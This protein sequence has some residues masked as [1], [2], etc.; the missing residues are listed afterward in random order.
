MAA[1]REGTQVIL[2]LRDL[3]GYR[4]VEPIMVLA[5][6]AQP[7]PASIPPAIAIREL[8]DLK[9]LVQLPHR[10]VGGIDIVGVHQVQEGSGFEFVSRPTQHG[11]PRWGQPAKAGIRIS[12]TEQRGIDVDEAAKVFERELIHT[13]RH[14]IGRT[15]RPWPGIFHRALIS[16]GSLPP[17]PPPHPSSGPSMFSAVLGLFSQDLAVDV[18]TSTTRVFL[19]G[20]GII[21]TEPTVVSV[22]TRHT[23]ERRVLAIGDD[24]LPM[25]G[26]TPADIHAVRPVDEGRL[27]DYE[28]AEAFLLHL[29]RRIH[30]RNTLIRARTV[31]PVPHD[32]GDME[33]R[34]IRDA[35]EAA[36]AREVHLVPRPLA[37]ALGAD[38]PIDEPTGVMVVDLGGGRTDVAVLSMSGIVDAEVVPGGGRGMDRD[39]ALHLERHEALHIGM[40]SAEQ[41]KLELA[42][43][44]APDRSQTAVARGRCM[45][46]G[47]PR[48]VEV[49]AEA[50][51]AAIHPQVKRIAAAIRQLLDRTPPELAS[52]IVDHGVVLVGGGA[53]LPHLDAVLRHYTG[54]PVVAAESPETA[55][56]NGAGKVLDELDLLRAV[57]C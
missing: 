38:L 32:A 46:R 23:G 12:D 18:G 6:P 20:S 44:C 33:L 5:V 39:I 14:T 51:T 22:H 15:P 55:V 24:A 26:R 34:A 36:G 42:A 8:C 2:L 47:I 1:L 10:R 13:S 31:L 48:A 27:D 56:V 40:A 43:A 45:R 9:P 30:G 50:V 52:D 19:R 49:S 21:L 16:S 3:G 28:V 11:G 54:L 4:V 57:A 41:L 17:S 53:G 7:G 37:A 29:F 35:I 25:L